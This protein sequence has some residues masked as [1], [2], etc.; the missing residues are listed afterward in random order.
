ML[1]SRLLTSA[2]L[3][4]SFAVSGQLQD[5]PWREIATPGGTTASSSENR[6]ALD[7]LED[8]KIY[9]T[10]HD[11]NTGLLSINKYDVLL[12][13]WVLIQQINLTASNVYFVDTYASGNKLY[14]IWAVNNSLTEINIVKIDE[15]E[16]LQNIVSNASSNVD[17]FQNS[18][19]DFTVD[20]VNQV[21][22]TTGK[23]VNSGVYVDRYNL[24]TG[25]YQDGYFVGFMTSNEPKIGLDVVNSTIYVA[26]NDFSSNL[27][28][29]SSLTSAAMSFTPVGGA[30]GFVYSSFYTGE[31]VSTNFDLVEK[32]GTSP[33]LVF[34]HFDMIAQSD[35]N[36]RIGLGSNT[37]AEVSLASPNFINGKT[38]SARG[39]SSFVFGNNFDT[40]ELYVEEIFA[41]GSYARVAQIFNPILNLLSCESYKLSHDYL[42]N[43]LAVFYNVTGNVDGLGKVAL[44]NTPPQ[45]DSYDTKLGCASSYSIYL[46]NI[47]FSDAEN[48]QVEIINS[49]QS[50]NISVVDPAS[51]IAYSTTNG[52]WVIDGFGQTPGF[53]D[54]TFYFT[55]G[56]DTV[57]ETVTIEITTPNVPSFTEPEFTFCVNEGIIDL[58]SVVDLAGGDFSGNEQAIQ[59]GL[60]DLS[61]FDDPALLPYQTFVDYSYSDANGCASYISVDVFVLDAPS[62]TLSVTNSACGLSSGEI[63]AAI[64]S[65]NGTFFTYWNTGSQNQ[66][67]I[68][69]LT[70]GIY[71]LNVFDELGCM[72]M[73]EGTVEASDVTVSSQITEVSC[74]DG[75]N[76]S[77]ELSVS[78]PGASYDVFWSTGASTFTIQDL[79]PGIYEAIITDVNGCSVTYSY[80]LNN[81]AELE[82]E[83]YTNY[84]TSCTASDGF[85]EAYVYN[86]VGNI[87]YLWSNGGTTPNITGLSSGVYSLTVTDESGC[88][89]SKT[90]YLLA[91]TGI[92]GF[93]E[94]QK[95]N[96]GSADGSI[97]VQLYPTF[98][99][100]IASI[101]WSNGATTQNIYNLVPGYYECTATQSDGCVSVFGWNVES[102]KPERPSICMVT[103][104]SVTTTNLIVWEKPVTTSIDHYRIYRETTQVGLFQLIDTVNYASISVFNDVVASPKTKS[105]RYKISAVNACGDE[106]SL[107]NSHKTIHLVTEDL[108]SGE[109][110]VTW[111]NYEG[112]LYNDYDLYRFTNASGWE[113]ILDNIP[114]L[115]LPYTLDTPSSIDGLDYMIEIDPGFQCTATFGKAQDYNSSRSNKARGDFNPGSGTGDPNNS[116]VEYESESMNVSI[117]PNPSN[118]VFNVDM[119]FSDIGAQAAMTITDISGKIISQQEVVNGI[120]VLNLEHI[121]TGIYLVSIQ[122]DQ[123]NI[124]VR[125]L[126]N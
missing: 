122:D 3:V 10:Y 77:I 32:E 50:T 26:G 106:S 113:L 31:S 99:E 119:D 63:Q 111:D 86:A 83:F 16:Q 71:Y 42:N 47:L 59:D 90:E 51:L 4:C 53:T 66:V 58:N 62:A 22:Y 43:R 40:N 64:T 68:S 92:F 91:S 75:N 112:F 124:V 102:F 21:A 109:Y 15:N 72:T 85:I 37:N 78:G 45:L 108:G 6:I 13:Q 48:D 95:S 107:S 93:G 54:L 41:N 118:G 8:G 120:N 57:A 27:I 17:A 67:I 125:I 74:H 100:T 1:F 84:A 73:A 34:T 89:I 80:T 121:K 79:T 2:I 9:F 123:N 70:P 97:E 38:G 98:G 101:E 115:A 24:T 30:S 52:D 19:I 5:K 20:E 14:V 18:S 12:N 94:V 88:S 103:V 49:F 110:K 55:D 69:N 104:D 117:Y 96:C 81:P 11:Q 65:P 33:E 36:M 82:L 29:Y 105:W 39:T 25:N 61:Q 56:L 7:V 76:G 28:V 23:D 114:Y 116:I 46:E 60:L 87:G 44:T 126:K 35:Y